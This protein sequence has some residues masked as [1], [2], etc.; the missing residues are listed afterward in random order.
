MRKHSSNV[1]I[2]KDSV[3]PKM[4]T[5]KFIDVEK[6]ER[7]IQNKLNMFEGNPS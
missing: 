1:D 2:C 6:A 5:V 4:L 7:L 3:R